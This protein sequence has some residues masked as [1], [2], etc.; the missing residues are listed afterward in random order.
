MNLDCYKN[1]EP[2]NE[3]EEFA[4]QRGRFL[5]LEFDLETDNRQRGFC[6]YM[7]FNKTAMNARDGGGLTNAKNYLKGIFGEN[8]EG[9][10]VS[11]GSSRSPD[12][13]RRVVDHVLAPYA[14]AV[15]GEGYRLSPERL[16]APTLDPS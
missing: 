15:S 11:P 3:E 12:L 8:S 7:A 6:R 9:E 4:R 13:F 14:K 1:I 16:A 2:G 5:G 10:G